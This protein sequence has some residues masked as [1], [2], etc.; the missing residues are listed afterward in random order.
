MAVLV[1]GGCGYIGSHVVLAL[2]EVG[3]SVVVIDNLINSS[4]E[5]LRRIETITESE[6]PFVLGDIRDRKCLAKVFRDYQLD[7]VIHLAGLKSV[8]ASL[9]NPIEYYENNI[10]GTSVLLMEM[11]RN[12][13]RNIVFS[14]SATVYG[15]KIPFPYKESSCLGSQTNP[16]GRSKAIVEGLLQDLFSS[17]N[18]WSICSL[19]YFNPV[20]A[21]PSGLIGEHPSG[22]PEN[23]MPFI[24]QVATGKLSK[25]S[26]FGSDYPTADGTC[27]RDYIHVMDLAEGHIVALEKL[28]FGFEAVNLGT[29]KPTSVFEL[30]QLFT[31]VT[32]IDIP[33]DITRRRPGDLP[34]FWADVTKAERV[35]GWKAKRDLQQ[36]LIDAWNWQIKNPNGY[37]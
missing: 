4:C 33:Y 36:M 23:L 34:E 2:L 17:N 8:S 13:V 12:G 30:I 35:F 7:G 22:V 10:H 18:L 25:L 21:H 16:Y 27:R 5:S 28:G 19:R 6:I 29:G 3:K 11:E 26:I 20:G 37:N 24:T 31:Q 32:G 15:D 14:S 1:T 9:I